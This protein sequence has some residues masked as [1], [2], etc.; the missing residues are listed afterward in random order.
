MVNLDKVMG[1]LYRTLVMKSQRVKKVCVSGTDN[2]FR[3]YS[4]EAL[5]RTELKIVKWDQAKRVVVAWSNH[6]S[7]GAHSSFG[8]HFPHCI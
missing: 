7:I 5:Y 3:C 4:K 2:L 6:L 8:G 1:L